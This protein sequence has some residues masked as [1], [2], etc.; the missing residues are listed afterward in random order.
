MEKLALFIELMNAGGPINW[1][2]LGLYGVNLAL[3]SWRLVYFFRSRSSRNDLLEAL[4]RAAPVIAGQGWKGPLR[5]VLAG[6]RGPLCRMAWVFLDHAEMP[7]AALSERLDREGAFL[8]R[9][10]ERGL[11]WFSFAGTAA[12]LLGLLGTIT[13]LMDAFFQIERRGAAADISYL[14]GGI[15]EAMITT[16][17]GLVTAIC[18]LGCAR[19][20]EGLSTSRLKDMAAIVSLLAERKALARAPE[21]AAAGDAGAEGGNFPRAAYEN[22]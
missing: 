9:E 13:G 5:N 10:M 22:F 14:S 3:F 1:V 7:D 20:F 16:A 4:E 11:G 2:I 15:R 8:K 18:A 6:A 12:P 21:G 17:T 19:L